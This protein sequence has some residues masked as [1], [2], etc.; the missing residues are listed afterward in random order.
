M[1]RDTFQN[2]LQSFSRRKP[3][4]PFIVELMSGDRITVE[5]PEA[6]AMR[7]EVAVYINTD[8]KFSLFDSTSVSQLTEQSDRA[9][10]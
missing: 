8:G 3:F 2:G 7:G 4:R 5:H 1:T 9:S 6:L 10:A